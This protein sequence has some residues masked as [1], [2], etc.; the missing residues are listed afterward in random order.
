M[1]DAVQL[2]CAEANL[3]AS[4]QAAAPAYASHA[5]Y[6]SCCW[7]SGILDQS[8]M[9]T[10]FCLSR[11]NS[12]VRC[13]RPAWHAPAAAAAAAA[14]LVGSSFD[15]PAVE[16]AELRNALQQAYMPRPSCSSSSSIR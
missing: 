16:Q 12:E 11:L 4:V 8:D 9:V 6:C 7:V 5:A 15:S 2:H 3:A 13:S 10:R 14:A 1:T